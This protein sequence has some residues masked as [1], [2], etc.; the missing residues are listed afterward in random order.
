MYPQLIRTRLATAPKQIE[1]VHTLYGCCSFS[2]LDFTLQFGSDRVSNINMSF[3]RKIGHLTG[4]K[5]IINIQTKNKN[6]EKVMKTFNSIE[7]V[8][9]Y[10]GSQ[11]CNSTETPLTVW[12]ARMMVLLMKRNHS[13]FE[14]VQSK[15]LISVIGQNIV[16]MAQSEAKREKIRGLVHQLECY[17]TR[18]DNGRYHFDTQNYKPRTFYKIFGE[19]ILYVE[20]KQMTFYQYMADHSNLEVDAESMKSSVNYLKRTKGETR[21]E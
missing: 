20:T 21:E 15:A 13:L 3:P 5:L 6:K 17:V 8:E 7:E 11:E 1:E 14:D 18:I 9:A 16:N 4:A 2:T 12:N 10:L 19:I